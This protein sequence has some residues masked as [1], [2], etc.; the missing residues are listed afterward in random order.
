[1]SES[2]PASGPGT[3]G[4]AGLTSTR[5]AAVLADAGPNLLPSPP[6]P[7]P[8]RQLLAQLVHLFAVML[9]AASALALLAGLP[10]LAV[11]IG[12]V[13]LV[14][15]VFA[16][17][18]EYRADRAAGTLRE[19]LPARARVRRDGMLR[20]VDVAD[21]VPGD[22]VVLRA[23]ER[24][25]A[26]L[27]V[28]EAHTLAVDE[29]LLTGESAAVRPGPGGRLS[30]GTFVLEG[31]AEALVRATGGATRLAAI[32]A[33]T[34]T[35]SSV[36]TPLHR[37]LDRVV[38]AVSVL[39]VSVGALL[40]GTGLWLGLPV[41]DAFVFGLGVTVALVPEGLLPTVTL[42][43]ARAAERMAGEQ[44]LVR[45]LDAV[46]TLGATTFVCTDKTG[47]LTRN[48]M[49]VTAVWTPES[50]ELE[51]PGSGYD[52]TDLLPSALASAVAGPARSASA[53][54]RG[55]PVRAEDGVW[56][57]EGDPME[58]ALVVLATRSGTAGRPAVRRRLPYTAGRHR[59]SVVTGS[60]R[61]ARV[62]V[63]GAP[64]AFGDVGAGLPAA[65]AA[66]TARGLRVL[67]VATR[68]AP[69]GWADLPAEELETDLEVLGL[70]G[71]EDPP[72]PGV[73]EA[74]ARCRA[75]GIRVAV[76]TGDHPGT[77][78]AV[79]AEV[80]LADAA[81]V[82]LTSADLPADEHRLAAL[83]TRPGGVVVA[84][85][86]PEDKLRIAQSL[87][88]SGEVVA[89]T[90][91]GVND[92]PALRAADVG[93]AMGAGGSD[94]AREAADVVLLEDRFDSIVAGVELGRATFTNIRRF[95]TYHLTDNVAELAPFAAWA[96]STGSVPLAIGVLQVLALDIGTDVLPALALGA[97]PPN[98]RTLRGPART[99]H[100]VDGALLRRAL[101]VLGLTEAVGV[102]A[103][104]VL[105]LHLGGWS[106]GR[107]PAADLLATASGS[108]F[109]AVAAGQL[110]N[111]V[112]C[113]SGTRP[114]W[115]VGL[116]GNRLLAGAI[117]LEALL[118]L[119]FVGLPPMQ[120]V[121][122]GRWPSAAGFLGALATAVAVTLVDGAHK[123]LRRD[124]G[125]WEASGGGGSAET[126]PGNPGPTRQVPAPA[127]G[128]AGQRT[129]WRRRQR[130]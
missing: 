70:L 40:C 68:P 1:M 72:R 114:A 90:G 117:T 52:P 48:E 105:V 103:T 66:M 113:R 43:L 44:V 54:V 110:A 125:P 11:A 79:A 37:E 61:R 80:G 96:L 97:E 26:D 2:P 109:A 71:L 58:V 88:A 35:T 31:E 18:Q 122:G 36:R 101:G 82:A 84:R 93:V 53:C 51:V 17:V 29:S 38:R 81:T 119:A 32:A 19:L 21:V 8:L 94:V 63:L 85:V 123:A 83:L 22:V 67:A 121:L 87:Q 118:C 42:S 20:V 41:T 111:A 128:E 12:V 23:G 74:V 33:L 129:T 124:L 100:L 47:T 39:A 95:L 112:A 116:R 15:G 73:R 3:E 64:E 120:R 65:L 92:G 49:S 10:A 89:M 107:V 102:L 127:R 86:S 99:R 60:G 5:A 13:V 56:G 69:D 104:F 28:L 106:W 9:W 126:G 14:N 30:C 16:F 108:A 62:H 55:H 50:G 115:R 77:A 24:V 25:C 98:S 27:D 59:S 57:P 6:G 7:H 45:R 78:L 46:E 4:R 130:R 34:R 91:D 76:V 75:A